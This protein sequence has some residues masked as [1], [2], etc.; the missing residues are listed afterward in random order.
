MYKIEEFDNSL[1]ELMTQFGKKQ[2][3]AFD[4]W[5][6]EGFPCGVASYSGIYFFEFSDIYIDMVNNV[7]SGLIKD[8]HDSMLDVVGVD[9]C[10]LTPYVDWLQ[11]RNEI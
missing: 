8:Y 1:F 2:G 10:L 3:L 5:V 9:E 11:E 6:E 7:R 4:Y